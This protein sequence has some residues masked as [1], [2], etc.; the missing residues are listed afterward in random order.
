MDHLVKDEEEDRIFDP[1]ASYEAWRITYQS[2]EKAARAAFRAL[3][4]AKEQRERLV[5][6]HWTVIR[7]RDALRTAMSQ[8]EE[9]AERAGVNADPKLKRI[10][11]IALEVSKHMGARTSTPVVQEEV[12]NG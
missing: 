10:L 6:L 9:I 3:C 8:I 7:Q 11:D 2:S 5:K 1:A 4:E 12:S